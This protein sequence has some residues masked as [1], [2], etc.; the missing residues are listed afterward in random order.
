[1]KGSAGGTHV[2]N[3]CRLHPGGLGVS[4]SSTIRT[5]RHDGRGLGGVSPGL[6]VSTTYG[7]IGG[8]V[9]RSG[10]EDWSAFSGH[11][12]TVAGVRDQTDADLALF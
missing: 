1:V 3:M 4:S 12:L 2:A 10:G 6:S 9:D 5:Q 7:F 11:C 8:A